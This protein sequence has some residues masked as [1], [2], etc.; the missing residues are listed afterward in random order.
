[1]V[2]ERDLASALERASAERLGDERPVLK[3]ETCAASFE[4]DERA[5]AQTCPFCGTAIV[6][7]PERARLFRPNGV[8][9]FAI[10]RDTARERLR[11]WLAGLWF[12]PS[13]LSRKAEA[14]A[15]L[16]GL[17]LPFWT[18]DCD[19]ETEYRGA[20]GLCITRHVPV[21]RE[22]QGRL[23]IEMRPVVELQ[24]TP[25]SGRV[26]RH[27]DDVLV[28][29]TATLPL[30][31]LGRAGRWNTQALRPYAP[32]WP[33]GFRSGFYDIPLDRGFAEAQALMRAVI[34]TD[35]RAD[36]GGEAQRIEAMR[37]RWSGATFKHVLLL[38]WIAAHRYRGRT[39]RFVVNG[40]T[41]EAYGERP[42]NVWKIAAAVLAAAALAAAARYLAGSG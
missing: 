33:A 16:E 12:A 36:I 6:A 34:E 27:F 13:D 14:E 8:V 9:P 25:V 30:H 37:T 2:V 3:C 21:A 40:Q 15:R 4:A 41:G 31:D 1:M 32:E 22:V 10:P 7:S 35:I 20:R 23:V 29:A 11:A 18:Y 26:A 24:G 39:W 19:T 38:L 28:P 42:W 17:Y 5:G